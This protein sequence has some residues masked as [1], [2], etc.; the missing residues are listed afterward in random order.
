[1]EMVNKYWIE[2]IEWKCIFCGVGTDC[3]EHYIE[4]CE[5][6]RD[7]FREIEEDK[8]KLREMLWNE[9]INAKKLLKLWK[10]MEYRLKRRKTQKMRS[11]EQKDRKIGKGLRTQQYKVG[12]EIRL[13]I[14]T[15]K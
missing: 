5:Y 12:Q 10:E 7:Q 11:K 2:E 1:M 15:N 4:E 9:E 14:Q 3:L 8:D 13:G 6:T